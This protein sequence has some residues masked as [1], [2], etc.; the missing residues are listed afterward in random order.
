MKIILYILFFSI[1]KN[2][3]S[4]NFQY[5]DINNAKVGVTCGGDLHVDANG[6]GGQYE[7]PKGSGKSY[8][9]ASSLWIGGLDTGNNL[10]I[11]AQT[12][13]QHGKDFWP[14]PLSIMD[15]STNASTVNQ[16]DKIWKLDRTDIQ[17]FINNFASGNVQNGTYIPVADLLSWPGNGDVALNQAPILAPFVDVNNDGIYNPLTDGDYPEIKGDQ[18]LFYIVNDNYLPHQS[19]GG[20]P[21]GVEIHVMVYAYGTCDILSSNPYLN[22]TTFYNYK[23][24]NR[25]LNTYYSMSCSMFSDADVGFYSDDKIGYD[26][27]DDYG[28]FYDTSWAQ[29]HLP[30]VGYVLLKG[31]V[32]DLNDGRDNDRDGFIDEVGEEIKTSNF[33]YFNN[34]LPGALPSM[35]DPAN[36]S[37]YYNYMRSI[38]KDGTFLTCG[39]NGYGGTTPTE[40]AFSGN[41]YTI[42]ACGADNWID[43]TYSDRRFLMSMGIFAL[44]A[45]EVETIEFAHITSFDSIT[46]NPLGKLDADAQAV[47]ALYDSNLSNS[48]LISHVNE[49]DFME[50]KTFP[51]PAIHFITITNE[52]NISSASKIEI[53]DVLGNIVIKDSMNSLRKEIDIS[54]L[55][56]GVYFIKLTADSKTSIKKFVKE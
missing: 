5:L 44:E 15:A 54:L 29:G 56:E 50:Y 26:Y 40:Y 19:S 43:T 36:S 24:Y 2:I 25:S 51:N 52:R 18:A 47:R 6:I 38:W 9:Y 28:Y 34:S 8:D 53:M 31:P 37:N 1:S 30:V 21:L 35:T 20:L 12:Y 45:G 10:H 49:Y 14:G 27:I 41:T 23:I 17:D 4:Q 22:Y 13:R 7:V 16:Y 11:A 55:T 33:S 3:F 39:G 46:N 32:A 48:C 42:G